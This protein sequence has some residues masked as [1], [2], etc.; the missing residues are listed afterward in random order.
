MDTVKPLAGEYWHIRYGIID[1][2]NIIVLVLE[3][4]EIRPPFNNWTLYTFKCLYKND[5]DGLGFREVSISGD[6]FNEFMMSISKEELE[7][8]KSEHNI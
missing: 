2:N 7:T 3:D 8:I 1:K 6:T 5:S 4:I